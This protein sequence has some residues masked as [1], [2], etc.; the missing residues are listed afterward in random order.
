M[1]LGSKSGVYGACSNSVI[2][3]FF[4]NC[5]NYVMSRQKGK[6][7]HQGLQ[8]YKETERVLLKPIKQKRWPLIEADIWQRV[9]VHGGGILLFIKYL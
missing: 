3:E 9:K 2:R 6:L 7:S 5:R 8:G 4:S 1:S